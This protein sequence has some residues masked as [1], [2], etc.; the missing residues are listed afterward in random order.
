MEVA[1]AGA[2]GVPGVQE[3]RDDGQGVGGRREQEGLDLAVVERLDDGR[4]EVGH[5]AGGDDAEN[6]NH[7]A[8]SAGGRI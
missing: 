5:R 2:I 1:L 4:E 7:L 6:E 8:T 3:G